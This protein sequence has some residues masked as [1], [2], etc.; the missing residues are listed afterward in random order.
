M[1]DQYVRLQKIQPGLYN[2]FARSSGKRIGLV[3]RVENR[4]CG[5]VLLYTRAGHPTNRMRSLS[6]VFG[7]RRDAASEVWVQNDAP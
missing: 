7:S 2:V 3:R 1:A 6:G 5:Q 4:W